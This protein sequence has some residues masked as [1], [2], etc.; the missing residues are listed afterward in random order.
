MV[1]ISV[2]KS[3]NFLY[4]IN[5]N[6]SVWLIEVSSSNNNKKYFSVFHTSTFRASS[7]E[8][9]NRA[10]SVARTNYFVIFHIKNI[11]PVDRD[12]NQET[13]PEQW[14]IKSNRSQS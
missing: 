14:N 8:P 7:Y 9:G 3:S 11:I 13:Q 6:F 4:Q 1:A 10:G 2:H 5:D 12:E